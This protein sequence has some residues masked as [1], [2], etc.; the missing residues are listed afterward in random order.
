MFDWKNDQQ[1]ENITRS[2]VPPKPKKHINEIS[3]PKIEQKIH[4]NKNKEKIPNP[5]DLEIDQKYVLEAD[6]HF[7]GHGTEKDI[8]TA[9]YWYEKA[10]EHNN[11]KAMLVLGKIYE[12]GIGRQKDLAQAYAYYYE[13]QTEEPYALYCLGRFFENGIHPESD[14][15]PNPDLAYKYYQ[16]ASKSG[17]KDA[18]ARVG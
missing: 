18:S 2:I 11:T 1:M 12:E 7:F 6:C 8:E 9:I 13:A 15:Q 17:C 10:V 16:K 4:S 5:I 3:D 14:G